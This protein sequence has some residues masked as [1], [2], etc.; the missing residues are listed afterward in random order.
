MILSNLYLIELTMLIIGDA[1]DF[2]SIY[3]ATAKGLEIFCYKFKYRKL[4]DCGQSELINDKLYMVNRGVKEED[5]YLIRKSDRPACLVE[6]GF[7]SNSEDLN[8][9]ESKKDEF[10]LVIADEICNLSRS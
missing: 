1:N 4:A 3:I 10:A 5:F 2:V 9:I 6:L 7:I 8:L